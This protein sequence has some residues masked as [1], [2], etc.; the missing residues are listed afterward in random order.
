[1]QFAIQTVFCYSPFCLSGSQ[2]YKEMCNSYRGELA[3]RSWEFKDEDKI[4]SFYN[5]I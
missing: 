5:P 4:A 1:M 2:L 3:N